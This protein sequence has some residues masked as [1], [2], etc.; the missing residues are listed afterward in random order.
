MFSFMGF[1]LN[2]FAQISFAPMKIYKAGTQMEVVGI[3]DV[4]NDGLNDVIA[5]TGFYFDPVTDYKLFVFL[6]DNTGNLS[7]PVVYSYPEVY[8]G[9]NC[10]KIKD[11]N[12][13]NLQ[14]VII[15]YGDSVGIYFQNSSGSLNAIK[16]YYSGNNGNSVDGLGT[17]DL[18]N[19]GLTDIAISHWG[20]NVI[21][22][23]YQKINGFSIQNYPAPSGGYDQLEVGDVNNDKKDDVVLMLGGRYNAGIHVYHQNTSGTLNNYISYY[24]PPSSQI[25]CGIAIGDI[26]KDGMNDLVEVNSG[27]TPTFNVTIRKQNPITHR[28]DSQLIIPAYYNVDIVLL[29][30]F[31]CDDSKE[32]FVGHGGW[33]SFSIYEQDLNGKYNNYSLYRAFV[34]T[35][36]NNHGISIGDINNDGKKDVVTAVDNYGIV[37]Y[38]NQSSNSNLVQKPQTPAGRNMVCLDNE[39]YSYK[40]NTAIGDKTS[41]NLF[42]AEAGKIVSTFKDS[43]RVSWNNNWRG[44]AGIYINVK[45]VCGERNSDTVYITSNR[46]PALNLGRDTTLCLNRS[47]KLSAGKGFESYLWQNNSTDSVLNVT[48]GGT[49][50]VKAGNLCGNRYDT[51]HVADVPLPNIQVSDTILCSGSPIKVNVTIPGNNKYVW[52]DNSTSPIYT[53]ST[54]GN[55]TLKVTDANLCQNSKS[56][57]VKDVSPPVVKFPNDTNLCKS[58]KLELNVMSDGCSYLWQD[59]ST[60]PRYTVEKDGTYSVKVF[61]ECATINVSAVFSFVNCN[62]Y[63]DVPTA[64]SPD[65]DG[66]NDVLHAVGTNVDNVRFIIYNRW[67]QKVFESTSLDVGW[68]GTFQGKKLEAAVFIYYVSGKSTSDSQLIQ[69][70]GNVS[71]VR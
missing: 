30:D 5:G 54:A 12:N 61:N 6:Q 2:G 3:G 45:N 59:G 62:A 21:S 25:L 44:K 13:D 48:R 53:I 63:L 41:W 17:G 42:P 19:D 29:D 34:G 65:G 46:L 55:Y 20:Q 16:S 14:D 33:N 1:C 37:V 38:L 60:S 4:N 70:H 24:G 56:F 22:V 31:N 27:G 15:A 7:L 11:V 68:D 67:G 10:L 18:N 9:L 49:Y 64:F 52:Q 51:I 47:L 32:I 35:H 66:L 23:L 50:F 26:D 58:N 39:V 28:L 57:Q 36:I 8:P 40:T 71:L 69:K 43:C